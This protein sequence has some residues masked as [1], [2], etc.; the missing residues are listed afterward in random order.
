MDGLDK[1]VT[2]TI[3]HCKR[4]DID[5]KDLQAHFNEIKRRLA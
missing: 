1:V 2:R 5:P 3:P 4:F